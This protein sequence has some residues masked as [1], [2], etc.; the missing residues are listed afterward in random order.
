M[1]EYGSSRI[2]A[3]SDNQNEYKKIRRTLSGNNKMSILDEELINDALTADA[4]NKLSN[5]TD[6]YLLHDPS[7]IRKPYSAKAENL[8][9]VRDLKSNI[10]NGYSTHNIIAV[11]H[12]SK[13]VHLISHESYSNKDPKFL[14]AKLV[15]KIEAGNLDKEHAE[16]RETYD[17]D[18]WYNK[19]TL[20]KDRIQ[21]VSCQLKKTNKPQKITHIMDREFDDN[22]YFSTI[23]LQG[24]DFVI[25]SKKS[26]SIDSTIDP[27]AKKTMLMDSNFPNQH[28][29]KLQKVRFKNACYQDAFLLIEWQ[30]YGDYA[31][32]KIT[33]KT[34]EGKEIFQNP[35]LLITNKSVTTEQQAMLIY[36]IYLK[37]S[38]I[39]TV[40]KFLKEGLGWEEIQVRNFLTIQ[41][42]LSFCFFIAA[43]LYNIG[44]QEAYDDYV[45]LLAR[46]G[47]G[48][49]VV[50]K[51]Y[52]LQGIKA[53]LC[54][55]KVDRFFEEYKPS[56]DTI[57]HML[58]ASGAAV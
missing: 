50:S 2:Y 15:R 23:S 40:F 29:Q 35:M 47:G 1:L 36:Q 13:S 49:G 8:G 19:K 42:L 17:S 9:K 55:Y 56:E 38:R 33:A 57:E 7:D 44:D 37:R 32:V 43:Y 28:I 52:I 10:I 14:N 34:R 39:E 16:A 11:T 6:I 46:L 18:D 41:K 30:E 51:H 48:K 31:A 27:K 22:D 5:E 26:R 20:T 25:R 21:R 53:L 58:S 54:K 4:I 45:I 24:D 12:N 3:L